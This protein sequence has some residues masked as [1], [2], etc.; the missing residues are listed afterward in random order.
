MTS[1]PLPSLNAA[2]R[3][4]LSSVDFAWLRMDDPTNL[5]HINGVLVL[6]RPIELDALRAVI[7]KRLGAIPRFRNRVVVPKRGKPYWEPDPAF[8]IANHVPRMVLPDPG[9]DAELRAAIESVISTQFD[10]D[11]PPWSFR[12]IDNY[13]GGSVVLGRLHHCMGDGVALMLVLLS[14]TDRTPDADPTVR[15]PFLSLYSTH[16]GED[17]ELD[18]AAIRKLAEEIMPDGM[19]LLLNPAEAFRSVKGWL[20][21]PLATG[22]LGRLLLRRAD[23]PTVFKGPLG[24][25][26]RV[27]WSESLP[28]EEVKAVGKALGGTVNDVLLSAMSGGLRR[29][30]QRYGEPPHDLN[31]RAAMPVNLRTMDRMHQLGNQFGL[32][33]L[34]LPVGIA[35]PLKRLAE[36]SRRSHSLKRSLEPVVVFRILDAMGI[37]PHEIQKLVVKIFAT[38]ATAVMTNVPGPNRTLYL[39]GRPIQDLF[40]WVPQ[41]GRVGIGISICSYAGGV[42]MGVGTDAG[43]VPDPENIVAGFQ[44]EFE[45]MRRLAG[46][47]GEMDLAAPAEVS[48]F[49]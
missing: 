42:R 28:L 46:R 43:L 9:G 27:G 29:Y 36:L 20:K 6:E 48:R 35:D 41:A 8:D 30:L 49:A 5:M 33:F 4:P 15:N 21:G 17:G 19:R 34:S 47:T 25:P 40:F 7:E 16:K 10:F 14:L 18:L 44:E 22:N 45:A 3:E 32:I 26:K 23:P 13:R 12:L 31:F 24:V 37:V 11:H 1:P 2:G 39:A 38:K